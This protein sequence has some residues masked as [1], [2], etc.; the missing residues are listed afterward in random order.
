MTDDAVP[1]ADFVDQQRPAETTTDDSANDT[2]D[3]DPD[4]VTEADPA[5]FADQQREV[6]VPDDEP[7]H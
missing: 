6:P 7:W 4:A 1:I 3:I 2:E 5:D